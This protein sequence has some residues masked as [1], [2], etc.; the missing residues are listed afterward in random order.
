MEDEKFKGKSMPMS[1]LQLSNYDKLVLALF[2]IAQGIVIGIESS[3]STWYA[4]CMMD[5]YNCS[6]IISMAQLSIMHGFF[7]CG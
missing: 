5:K 4:V 3:C 2:I 1:I 6:M 7:L